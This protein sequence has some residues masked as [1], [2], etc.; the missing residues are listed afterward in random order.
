VEAI[1]IENG[2][3]SGQG[4]EYHISFDEYRYLIHPIDRFGEMDFNFILMKHPI[5]AGLRQT[6]RNPVDIPL[7]FCH[8][9]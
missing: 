6:N 2:L 7:F 8:I 3:T 4:S 5:R 1:H 9:R